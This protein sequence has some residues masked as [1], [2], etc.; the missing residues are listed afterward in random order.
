MDNVGNAAD[1]FFRVAD[2][3]DDFV[4]NGNRRANPQ[5]PFPGEEIGTA[6]EPGNGSTR[7]KKVKKKMVP[8]IYFGTR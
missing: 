4:E 3:D 2:G 5:V 1:G 6:Q 8:K 7:P